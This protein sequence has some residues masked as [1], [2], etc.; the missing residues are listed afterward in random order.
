M[1]MVQQLRRESTNEGGGGE[2]VTADTGG[3]VPQYIAAKDVSNGPTTMSKLPLYVQSS[4][5]EKS[6][7]GQVLSSARERS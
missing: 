1:S 2:D 3:I 6:Q 4:P 5:V 7:S